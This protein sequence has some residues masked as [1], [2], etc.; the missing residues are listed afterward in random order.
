LADIVK[1]TF[2]V[3][4]P[5]T[6]NEAYRVNQFFFSTCA[7]PPSGI[8]TL[9]YLGMILDNGQYS[10]RD[11]YNCSCPELEILTNLCREHGAYGAR[12]T[13]AGWGGCI[14]ALVPDDVVDGFLQKIKNTY[15]V[16]FQN[17]DVDKCL[18][19]TKPGGGACILTLK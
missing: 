15:F 19:K 11:L 12:L 4:T 2:H 7:N 5:Y 6:F 1:Q 9:Q 13:G 3:D 17:I 10:C 8:N 16:K 14:I 18:F